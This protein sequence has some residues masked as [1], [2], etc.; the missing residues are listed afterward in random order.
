MRSSLGWIGGGLIAAAALAAGMWLG[1][2]QR[3]ATAPPVAAALSSLRTQ[4]F[5]QL[6]GEPVKLSQWQGQVV[7]VNFWATW[8]PPCREEIPGLVSAQTRWA[9]KGV[10]VVG[11]AIDS[12]SNVQEYASNFKFNYPVLLVGAEGVDLVRG[13]GNPSGGLPF[14]VVLGRD[15]KVAAS[16]LGLLRERDLDEILARITQDDR[17]KASKVGQIPPIATNFQ[18]R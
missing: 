6:D 13:L 17:G 18:L 2:H 15:G 4:P 8:C 11:I 5:A 3:S 16:H 1:S 10:Q 7:V 12:P 9:S 14:T